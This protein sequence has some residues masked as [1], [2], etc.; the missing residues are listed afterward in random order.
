MW[1]TQQLVARSLV[2]LA[3]V[4]IPVQGLSTTTY[5]GCNSG[6]VCS[7]SF[8]AAQASCCSQQVAGSWQ[9]GNCACCSGNEAGS[10]CCSSDN[11]TAGCSCGDNCQCGQSNIPAKPAVPPAGN[12]SPERIFVD[13]T[14]TAS[15]AVVYL[16]STTRPPS[17]GQAGAGILSALDRCVTLCRFTV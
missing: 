2:W 17:N 10:S 13:S 12:S 3:T 9:P 7:S 16:A 15:S 1:I 4:A 11:S 5:Y 8:S 14:A 6:M